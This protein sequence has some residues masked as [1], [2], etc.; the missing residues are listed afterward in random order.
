MPDFFAIVGYPNCRKSS[1][2]RAL[3]GVWQRGTRMVATNAGTFDFFIQITSLQEA[4]IMPDAFVTEMRNN[5]SQRILAPLWIDPLADGPVTYPNTA[6]YLQH[7]LANGWTI[8]E[9]VVLGANALP[10]QLPA[11][12]PNPHF[13]GNPVQL[14]TNEIASRIRNWWGWL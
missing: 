2:V 9:V 5:N 7:F 4:R 1:T 14:A 8:R 6:D 10:Y 11:G 13:V 12:C 3:T